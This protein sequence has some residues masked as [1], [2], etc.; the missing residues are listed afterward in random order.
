MKKLKVEILHKFLTGEYS[1]SELVEVNE[2]LNES[3]DNARKLFEIEEI[4]HLK[5]LDRYVTSQHIEQ[6]ERSLEEKIKA[7]QKKKEKRVKKIKKIRRWRQIAASVAVFFLISATCIYWYVYS[8][9]SNDWIIATSNAD[10][11]EIILSDSSKVWLNKFS[12]LKYPSGFSSKERKVF[13]DGEAYFEVTKKME[14]PFIVEN[15]AMNVR[16]LGTSFNLSCASNEDV[17]KATLIEGEIEVKGNNEEGLII[18]SPG[19][20]AELNKKN[21]RLTVKQIEAK[22]DAVWHNNLIPFENANMY[23]IAKVL[24]NFY[25]VKIIVSP[26]MKVD[27]TYSGVLQQKSTIDS[28]LILLKNTIPFDYSIN[29]KS[30]HVFPH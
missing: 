11:T 13:L 28:V 17:V 14:Q 21:K 16:V 30:V 25:D 29:G 20:R 18:L 19:Q 8:D 26:E 24:E 22:L 15:D 1:E 10:V 23:T 5:D 7:D 2:W 27:K 12:T 4:Y 3:A 6:A 9:S